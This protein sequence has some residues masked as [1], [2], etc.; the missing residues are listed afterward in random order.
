[1]ASGATRDQILQRHAQ[2]TAA[3]VEQA[4]GYAAASVKNEVQLQS[5]VGDEA[6]ATASRFLG[7]HD[8]LGIVRRLAGTMRGHV[9]ETP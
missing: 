4:L 6:E 9:P 5:P 2:L 3:D 8:T 7:T 1:M